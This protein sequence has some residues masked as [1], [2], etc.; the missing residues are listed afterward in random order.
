MAVRGVVSDDSEI[1]LLLYTWVTVAE[2]RD[3]NWSAV[4]G[5]P[6]KSYLPEGRVNVRQESVS[7]LVAN[8]LRE[9]IISGQLENGTLLPRMD[10]LLLEF[11]VSKPS[12]REALRILETEGLVTVKRGKSG[13][14]VVHSPTAQGAAYALGFVLENQNVSL[15][16]LA[17]AL[18]SLEPLCASMCATN[19]TPELLAELDTLIED[20][21]RYVG[22]E[23][24]AV[25][26]SRRFHEQIVAGCGNQ[27]L[28][29]VVGALEALWSTHQI[30]WAG[31]L[32]SR[33]D[34]DRRMAGIRQH[35]QIV[36]S[37]RSGDPVKAH[38]VM[39]RHLKAGYAV[40]ER[41]SEGLR[42]Q[43]PID[44]RKSG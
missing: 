36:A 3:A 17:K 39:S 43:R 33:F 16:D 2:P 6:V 30:D 22:D 28:I 1:D 25:A 35:E 7:Q 27:T 41:A 13:G 37:I 38:R 32:E 23:I 14:A 8:V 26:I 34:S 18:S 20:T 9:R 11:N 31:R 4:G 19:A 24:A 10:D 44:P 12:L 42:V 40:P 5:M 15:A 29:T 21:K